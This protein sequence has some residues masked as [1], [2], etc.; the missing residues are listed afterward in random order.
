MAR[1]FSRLD[2]SSKV[3]KWG[4]IYSY[5]FC[6]LGKSFVEERKSI[7]NVEPF[8]NVEMMVE[9]RR[10]LQRRKISRVPKIRQDRG[11]SIESS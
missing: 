6:L 1:N 8:T 4:K 7:T 3:E 2:L 10:D 11:D 5:I 9:R